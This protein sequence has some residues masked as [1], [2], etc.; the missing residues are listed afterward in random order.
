MN[1]K[2]IVQYNHQ[3]YIVTSVEDIYDEVSEETRERCEKAMLI[4]PEPVLIGNITI[5]L[6]PFKASRSAVEWI[7]PTNI[8]RKKTDLIVR[9]HDLDDV[10]LDW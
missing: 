9:S 8:K 4:I 5:R 1:T 2:S 7:V 6:W 10:I 3:L